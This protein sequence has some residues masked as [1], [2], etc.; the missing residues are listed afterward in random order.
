MEKIETE[1]IIKNDDINKPKNSLWKII[2]SV[3]SILL[4]ASGIF[5]YLK[6]TQKNNVISTKKDILIGFSITTLQEE[7]WQKDKAEFLK[8]AEELGVV[9]DFQEAQNNSDKQ[10]SQIESMIIK[11]VDV[12]VVV[13][14]DSNALAP[15]INKAHKAG[16]KI[17]SYDRMINN[18]DIDAYISFDNKKIGEDEVNYVIDSLKDKMVK[19]V[20]LKIAYVGGSDTDNNAIS[21]RKSSFDILQ[22][23]INSGKIEIVFDKFTTN[24]NPDIAYKN[25][26][27]YLINNSNK[28]D[29]VIAAND[30]T[31]FGSIT[32]LSEFGLAGKIPVSGQDAELAA[33]QRIISGTQTLTIYKSINKLAST[34]VETAIAFANGEKVNTNYIINNGKIDVPSILLEPVAV[35]KDNMYDIIIKDGYHSYED[36]YK[37]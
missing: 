16:I 31:A 2:V 20:K 24:W 8:K 17:I 27:N 9:V 14:Y 12:I 1:N 15:V 35:T 37:K 29:A 13:P 10:I 7:R 32:A 21:L 34:A 6:F 26:K 18:S 5:F 3:L 19:G 11:G 36:V 28:I 33:C 25:M 23:L 4:I 30:G 22:P